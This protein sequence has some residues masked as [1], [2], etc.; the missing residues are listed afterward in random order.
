MESPDRVLA[1]APE[2]RD[3]RLDGLRGL[4]ILPVML[5]HLT[6]FGYANQPLDRALTFLPSLGWTSVDLFFVLSGYLITGI[7]WRARGATRYF[8]DF[9]ARRALRIFPLYYAVLFFFFVIAPRLSVF[10][11]PGA[12]WA[13]GAAQETL[14]YWLYLQNIHVALAGA[15]DHNFLGIAWT[16]S[17][18]EQFYLVWPLVVL[19][20]SRRGLIRICVGLIVGAFLLRVALVAAGAPSVTILTF[21]FCRIDTLATGALIAILAQVPGARA[22]MTAV[23]RRALPVSALLWLGV[24]LWARHTTAVEIPP[25]QILGPDERGQLALAFTRSPWLQT[26]GYSFDMGFYASLLLCTLGARPGSLLARCFESGFLRGFGKYSYAMYLLHV[27]VSEFA[28]VLYDPSRTELPFVVEQGLWWVVALG[29]IYLVSAASWYGFESR[30][31]RLKRFFP[32]EPPIPAGAAVSPHP[33][34][35]L[36]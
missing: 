7:L 26:F 20:A 33:R 28:R 8:R 10:A 22:R 5:Y 13:P 6:F 27:F 23:A 35:A 15:F 4:A 3:P 17:I 18:E 1:A 14:W 16:L 21:T 9:Y 11:D 32:L 34:R 12:L 30:C 25:G 31:L 2:G 19:L 29:L 24:V 36:E